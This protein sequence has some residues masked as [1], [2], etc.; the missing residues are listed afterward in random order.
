[1]RQDG[2]KQVAFVI[3]SPLENV[4]KKKKA[5]SKLS[6]TAIAEGEAILANVVNMSGMEDM[7]DLMD[8]DDFET[9]GTITSFGRNQ[10]H[11]AGVAS[12]T[13][14]P[15]ISHI[16][17]SI[18]HISPIPAPTHLPNQPGTKS[19]LVTMQDGPLLRRGDKH[20]HSIRHVV[21]VVPTP[22]CPDRNTRL[23]RQHTPKGANGAAVLHESSGTRHVA[24]DD[25][26]PVSLHGRRT[27]A[28]SNAAA[29]LPSE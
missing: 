2:A 6:Q 3:T 28:V 10:Q 9:E 29:W 1:L 23:P 26:R 22:T 4:L 8:D 5:P 11:R 16:S 18:S 20:P 19:D 27:N 24:V 25:T 12:G 21:S 17:P 7:L 15:L 14:L 13:R